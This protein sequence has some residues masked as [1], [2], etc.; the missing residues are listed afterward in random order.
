[1]QGIEKNVALL[2]NFMP[3]IQVIKL[4]CDGDKKFPIFEMLEFLQELFYC[5][6]RIFMFVF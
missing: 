5:V 6:G 3:G 1:M 4:F 2:Q